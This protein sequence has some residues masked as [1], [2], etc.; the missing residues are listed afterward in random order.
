MITSSIRYILTLVGL[1]L[2][3]K[4]DANNSAVVDASD[5]SRL[6]T[7]KTKTVPSTT[8]TLVPSH[9]TFIRKDSRSKSH[10]KGSKITITKRGANQRIGLMKFDTSDL[11]T[12]IDGTDLSSYN[13]SNENNLKA[14]LRL[15]VAETHKEEEPVVVKIFRLNNDF[16]E[17]YVSWQNFDGFTEAGNYVEFSVERDHENKIGQVEVSHLLRP[18]EDTVFAFIIEDQGHVKFHSKDHNQGGFTP[19]LILEEL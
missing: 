14:Y 19:S 13:G 2:V 6:L 4:V 5:S 16:N 18:G 7:T 15:G 12:E 11:T 10:G 17:D 3:A 1:V 9:D 8:T